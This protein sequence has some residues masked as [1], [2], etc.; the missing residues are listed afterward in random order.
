MALSADDAVDTAKRLLKM[1]EPEQHRLNKIAAYTRGDASSV[2]VPRGAKREYHWLIRRAKMNIL[3]LVV[4]VVAQA[5]Y[6][7]GYRPEKKDTNAAAW[8]FWQANR[9]DARQHGLHRSALKYGVA[10]NVVLPGRMADQSTPV[11]TPT[12]PRRMTAFYADP[13]NDEW[14]L[15]AIDDTV[16]NT[17]TAQKRRVVR[18]LDGTS[19]Y[20]M[21]GEARPGGDLTLDE[22][23]DHGLGVCPVVRYLNGADLDGEDCV[24]GE[25]EPLFEM[26]DQLNAT[27]FNL[28]M[29]Q[30]YSAFRQRWVT[31]MVPNDE[32]GRPRAPFDPR[33]DAVWVGEDKDTKFGEFGQTD[34][35][36]YLESREATIRHLAT[37]SQVPPHNLLGQMVNLSAEALNAARDGLNSKIA[38]R[39]SSFG[40]SHEQT[41]RLAA[42]AAGDDAGWNDMSAQVVWRDTESRSLAQ[43]VD[44]LGK[45][46]QM[47]GVPAEELW[48]KVPGI[49]ET[50]VARWKAAAEASDP[51]GKI[52]A[53]L[54]MQ[55]GGVAAMPNAPK[56]QAA[57]ESAPAPAG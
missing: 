2:Y 47:L 34:L 27:T 57:G 28:L 22:A 3:P 52:N 31:G 41:M 23:E 43:T 51:L 53:A 19:R 5:L 37:V 16:Q 14:P 32:N 45:L 17:A 25:V 7:D 6:V 29:A 36:G 56:P 13:V 50:D 8:K 44:A 33:V 11:I 54:D 46:V 24:L 35:G 49:S 55:F 4:T 42:L 15:F 40:E 30:Q 38:E 9:M 10:Y 39:K 20:T 1:R 21:S 18:L 26:Q 12:S 48:E